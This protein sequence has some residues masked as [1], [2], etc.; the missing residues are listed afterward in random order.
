MINKIE[1]IT[2]FLKEFYSDCKNYEIL[3][4]KNLYI[5]TI[6]DEYDN[7]IKYIVFWVDDKWEIKWKNILYNKWKTEIKKINV[8]ENYFY[9]VSFDNWKELLYNKSSLI[10]DSASNYII[11]WDDLYSFD[12]SDRGRFWTFYNKLK[13]FK[14]FIAFELGGEQFILEKWNFNSVSIEDFNLFLKNY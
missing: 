12:T 13:S 1:I 10:E 9:S 5:V 6:K 7:I 3:E 8:L 11:H 4:D 14:K 2:N